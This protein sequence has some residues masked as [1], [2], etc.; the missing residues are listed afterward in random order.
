[1]ESNLVLIIHVQSFFS[2]DTY[3]IIN[4]HVAVIKVRHGNARYMLQ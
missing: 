4:I 1:M 3:C 2:I